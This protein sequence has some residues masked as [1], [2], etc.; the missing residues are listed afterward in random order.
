MRSSRVSPRAERNAA[1]WRLWYGDLDLWVEPCAGIGQVQQI[2][3]EAPEERGIFMPDGTWR[4]F[5]Q[6]KR[7]L[8]F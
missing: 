5:E 3:I 6:P 4:P 8:G 2:T 7:R 1:N